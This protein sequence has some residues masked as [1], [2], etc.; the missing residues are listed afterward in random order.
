MRKLSA[1]YCEI[2]N[3]MRCVVSNAFLFIRCVLIEKD[4]SLVRYRVPVSDT[5]PC[6]IDADTGTFVFVKSEVRSLIPFF[7]AAM[8]ATQS[9]LVRYRY[10]YGGRRGRLP[11]LFLL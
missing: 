4:S 6:H 10:R 3:A 5:I 8:R 11:S 7:C 1:V 2:S 9:L